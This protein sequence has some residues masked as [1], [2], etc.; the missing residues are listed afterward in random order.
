MD[1]LGQRIRSA[2]KAQNFTQQDV[3]DAFG[4]RRVSVTQWE[5]D[6]TSPELDRIPELARIL[7]VTSDWLLKAKGSGPSP[8]ATAATSNRRTKGTK[9]ILTPGDQLVSNERRLPV[10]AAARGG[11][12]HS[13]ITFDA[14]EHL[15]MPSVLDGVKGGY[16]LLLTGESMVPSYRPSDIALINP[17]L[18]PMRDTDVVLYHSSDSV[19]N[20]HEAIIKRLIGFNDQVWKLEQYNPAKS[21]EELRAD[22]QICHRVVGKYNAR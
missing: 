10:Y 15:K 6:T 11:D 17:N 8:A 19:P 21:F 9:P 20:E 12:G 13:I 4:I 3:A 2:R 5:A 1:T 14:I 18:P 22:W 7:G 16:G